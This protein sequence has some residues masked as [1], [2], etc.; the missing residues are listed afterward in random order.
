MATIT[1]GAKVLLR[2][3]PDSDDESL[4]HDKGVPD[5]VENA[6][7]RDQSNTGEAFDV[8]PIPHSLL[9]E[10]SDV[11][12]VGA[13]RVDTSCAQT[14]KQHPRPQDPPADRVDVQNSQP[15]PDPQAA[16]GASQDRDRDEP[17]Q[18]KPHLSAARAQN[19][20][21]KK[22]P[23]GQRGGE[24]KASKSREQEAVPDMKRAD[25]RHNPDNLL[26]DL[27]RKDEEIRKKEQAL[28]RASD[29]H[30]QEVRKI[31]ELEKGVKSL[32]IEAKRNEK[33]WKE[34]SAE[35][36]STKKSLLKSQTETINLQRQLQAVNEKLRHSTE[37]LNQRADELKM[38]ESYLSRTN[39][40]SDVELKQMVEMVNQ[41]ITQ[42]CSVIVDSLDFSSGRRTVIP[43]AY[44]EQLLHRF[45]NCLPP[46]FLRSLANQSTPPDDETGELRIQIALQAVMAES[47]GFYARSWCPF[48]PNVDSFLR[49]MYQGLCSSDP[50]T[51]MRWR[52]M[53]RSQIRKRF[54]SDK[55]VEACHLDL[56]QSVGSLLSLC[57]WASGY[58]KD[59]VEHHAHHLLLIA[60]KTLQLNQAL[61]EGTVLGEAK[62][63]WF[64]AN[65]VFDSDCA[66]TDDFLK[67]Q[68]AARN[69]LCTTEL[70]LGLVPPGG[71]SK[72]ILKA[73]V[74]LE[75]AFDNIEK[76]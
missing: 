32:Q 48:N 66:D 74:V 46:L 10:H 68:L 26:R 69:I 55:E 52:V 33:A 12:T 61:L 4:I 58:I 16:G 70:G 11:Q 9:K 49:E 62:V 64:G 38:V 75:D 57:G 72:T 31:K 63:L 53:S 3:G 45:G 42:T 19:E 25:K 73:K 30:Q 29:Q 15:A 36:D 35:L 65:Q 76:L 6:D 34:T 27:K 56:S 23:G 41:E 17:E 14:E 28:R 21:D 20:S 54:I 44:C 71:S 59:K 50:F 2:P 43:D 22:S 18:K 60:T 7:I 1:N 13:G 40:N 47:V 37:L 5:A 39:K 8:H 24:A 51:A 67:P